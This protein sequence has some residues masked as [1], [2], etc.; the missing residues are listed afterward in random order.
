MNGARFPE[1]LASKVDAA[2]TDD[3][4]LSVVVDSTV[5]LCERLVAGGAPGLHFYCLNRPEATL[6]VIE[7]LD[8]G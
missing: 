8:E 1:A 5:E 4:R 7:A 3:E 6:G 2:T